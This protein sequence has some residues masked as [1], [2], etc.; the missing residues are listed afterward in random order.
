MNRKIEHI[1]SILK[2][3]A[4]ERHNQTI[5]DLEVL[6]NNL[7]EQVKAL[8]KKNKNLKQKLRRKSLL[9]CPNCGSKNFKYSY[10]EKGFICQQCGVKEVFYLSIMR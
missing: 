2:Q 9:S 1:E 10:P 7:K 6:N 4:E 8:E 3:Y 5:N